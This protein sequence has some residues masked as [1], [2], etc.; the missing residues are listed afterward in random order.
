MPCFVES[1]RN[2]KGDGSHS[3]VR[4]SKVRLFSGPKMEKSCLG[5]GAFDEA[6]LR[7]VEPPTFLIVVKVSQED[8]LKDFFEDW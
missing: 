1:C 3:F 2:V 8:F 5:A 7:S 4:G 6:T